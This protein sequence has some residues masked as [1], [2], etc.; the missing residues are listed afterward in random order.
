MKRSVLIRRFVLISIEGF[1]YILFL[2][3]DLRGRELGIYSE[4]VKYMSILVCFF[5]VL[6]FVKE[7]KDT[8]KDLALLRWAMCFTLVSD[9]FLLLLHQEE[10]GVTSFIVVQVLYW[11]RL[12]LGKVRHFKVQG[13]IALVLLF[14]FLLVGVEVDY[15]LITSVLYYTLLMCNMGYALKKS[16]N[17]IFTIGLV[18]FWLCDTNVALFNLSSYLPLHEEIYQGIY[19]ASSVLM[20]FFYL[21]SQVCIAL[22]YKEEA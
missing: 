15:L 1:F 11:Y 13:A 7:K 19:A 3:M 20:W 22:S 21:P 5:Y 17:S 2:W 9:T 14:L 16:E 8:R 10:V 18:L 6:A 12:P 4:R